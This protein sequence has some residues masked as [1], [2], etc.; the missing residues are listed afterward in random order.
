MTTVLR[1]LCVGSVLREREQLTFTN[2]KQ[3]TDRFKREKHRHIRKISSLLR[4]NS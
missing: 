3:I 2:N 4:V 1:V